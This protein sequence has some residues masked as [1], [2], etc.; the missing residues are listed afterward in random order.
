[1]TEIS[2]QLAA[3]ETPDVMAKIADLRGRFADGYTPE[4]I[5]AVFGRISDAGGPYLVCAWDYADRYGY[6]G[7]SRFYAET[8][9]G[10]H[11]V[12]PDI[13]LWL[14]GALETPGD[15]GAWVCAPVELSE[16]A[17]GDGFHNYAID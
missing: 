5:N 1:M 14:S 16:F 6:G 10:L 13:H 7:S 12:S 15:V 3:T 9:H 17:V 2:A 4:D 8:Q 11:E